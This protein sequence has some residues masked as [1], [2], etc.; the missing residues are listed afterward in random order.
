MT[1]FLWGGILYM[2]YIFYFYIDN[3]VHI[4]Y[5]VLMKFGNNNMW[6]F[7]LTFKPGMTIMAANQK[8]K[9]DGVFNE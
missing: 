8:L 7:D 6:V 4:Q 3:K 9:K 5:I 2:R 1:L